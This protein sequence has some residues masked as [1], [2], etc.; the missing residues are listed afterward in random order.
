MIFHIL[1]LDK[2]IQDLIAIDGEKLG[3]PVLA[4][5]HTVIDVFFPL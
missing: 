4:F 3:V 5:K 2:N 1:A